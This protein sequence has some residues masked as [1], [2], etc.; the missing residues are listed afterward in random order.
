MEPLNTSAASADPTPEV[1][2]TSYMVEW[3]RPVAYIDMALSSIPIFSRAG[4]ALHKLSCAP[5]RSCTNTLTFDPTS[6][7]RENS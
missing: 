1:V 7:D 3:V 6:D 5:Y 4:W 2:N